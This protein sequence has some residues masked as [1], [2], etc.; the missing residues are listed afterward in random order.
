[1]SWDE[2]E[3][4]PLEDLLE[5]QRV[6]GSIPSIVPRTIIISRTTAADV[7]SFSMFPGRW[8]WDRIKRRVVRWALLQFWAYQDHFVEEEFPLAPKGDQHG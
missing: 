8:P 1:M 3:A 7:M 5:M 4:D 2:P 6:L